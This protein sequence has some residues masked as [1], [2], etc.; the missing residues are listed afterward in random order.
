MSRIC[1]SIWYHAHSHWLLSCQHVNDEQIIKFSLIDHENTAWDQ[2]ENKATAGLKS[3]SPFGW[4]RRWRD[5]QPMLFSHRAEPNHISRNFSVYYGVSLL[6]DGWSSPQ[7]TARWCFSLMDDLVHPVVRVIW[8]A[9]WNISGLMKKTFQITLQTQ[10]H[11]VSVQSTLN[12]PH[13]LFHLGWSLVRLIR[14]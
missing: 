12:L 5:E 8:L 3:H 9:P 4:V 14:N 11:S 13:S 6:P 2:S 1:F 10:V 7:E